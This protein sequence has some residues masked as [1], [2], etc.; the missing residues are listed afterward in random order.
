MNLEAITL[1][2]LADKLIMERTTLTR[3]LTP[4]VKQGLV[5]V[6]PS[7][8]DARVRE[9]DI[10]NLGVKKYRVAVKYWQKAQEKL[11][12]KF[13]KKNWRELENSLHILRNL[14]T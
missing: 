8:G 4:L 5:R 1:T 6:K 12:N 2:G 14:V 10:T 7:D 11:L 13:G 9:I 3:N